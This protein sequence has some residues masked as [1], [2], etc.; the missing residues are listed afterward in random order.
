MIF[1]IQANRRFRLAWSNKTRSEPDLS[2]NDSEDTQA[3]G[4]HRYERFRRIEIQYTKPNL[5]GRTD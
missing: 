5:T 3:Q 4:A 1:E 2:T